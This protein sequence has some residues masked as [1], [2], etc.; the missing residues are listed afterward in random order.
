MWCWPSGRCS[1]EKGRGGAGL[2]R[3]RCFQCRW[4]DLTLCT[5]LPESWL[6][7]PCLALVPEQGDAVRAGGKGCSRLPGQRDPL[8]PERRENMECC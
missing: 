4:E 1:S 5:V 3:A 8:S 6:G 2:H 7:G